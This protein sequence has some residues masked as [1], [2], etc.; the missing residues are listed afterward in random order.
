MN[1]ASTLVYAV[2]RVDGVLVNIP[3][4]LDIEPGL[5]RRGR[6]E[7]NE[8]AFITSNETS[9]LY[10]N[11]RLLLNVAASERLNRIGGT[12][13]CMNLFDDESEEYQIQIASLRSSFTAQGREGT[14][15][16]N[17]SGPEVYGCALSE[18]DDSIL[19]GNV[20]DVWS[21]IDVVVPDVPEWSLGY[22]FH[23]VRDSWS[24]LS[25]RAGGRFGNLA[26]LWPRVNGE[27]EDE[28]VARIPEG[29][30]NLSPGDR[31]SLEFESSPHGTYLRVNG[32]E[33]LYLAPDQLPRRRGWMQLCTGMVAS[34]P[35]EYT[36]PF[37]NL[38]AWTQ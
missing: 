33:V 4:P 14:F 12:S 13:I 36:I 22:L 6:G 7:M 5:L 23:R 16:S 31:N 28:T 24:V 3:T 27:W 25:I 37:S 11:G 10:L 38:W 8:L 2:S 18:G 19:G 26:V 34:E 17:T 30:L 29:V 1:Q 21:L 35:E 32:I 9:N 20:L 15:N